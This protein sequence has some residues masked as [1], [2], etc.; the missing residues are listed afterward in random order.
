MMIGVATVMYTTSYLARD[1][2]FQELGSSCRM[3]CLAL[4]ILD[5]SSHCSVSKTFLLNRCVVVAFS[6]AFLLLPRSLWLTDK[7]IQHKHV[8][9]KEALHEYYEKHG[10]APDHH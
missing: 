2:T 4:V 5:P 10:G 3:A 7:S 8:V 6:P 1:C 9:E